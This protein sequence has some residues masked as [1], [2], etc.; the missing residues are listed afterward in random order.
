VASFF[1]AQPDGE[2][3]KIPKR[4]DPGDFILESFE[5]YYSRWPEELQHIPEDIA[6]SWAY[7]HNE[8]VLEHSNIYNLEK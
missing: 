8:F 5:S 3:M 2:I 4:Q 6:R 7:H 1:A